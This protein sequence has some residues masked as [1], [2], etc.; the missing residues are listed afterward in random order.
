MADAHN[1]PIGIAGHCALTPTTLRNSGAN[2]NGRSTVRECLLLVI[3]VVSWPALAIGRLLLG[4]P[5]AR[6]GGYRRS[7]YPEMEHWMAGGDRGFEK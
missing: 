7:G 6:I 2:L 5:G 3:R 1:Q 4:S